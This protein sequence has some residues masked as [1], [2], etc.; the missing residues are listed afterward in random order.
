MT[1]VTS[2]LVLIPI[3]QRIRAELAERQDF[4]GNWL[5]CLR[6]LEMQPERTL[7]RRPQGRG[8]GRGG[9][10]D[11]RS[12]GSD[13]HRPKRRV[14]SDEGKSPERADPPRTFSS[15]TRQYGGIEKGLDAYI[16]HWVMEV[17]PSW[18]G[19]SD[20]PVDTMLCEW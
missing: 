6:N 18:S 15:V 19:G 1:D 4:I 14:G 3:L 20:G 5:Y 11:G 8:S 12:E 9:G 13:S 17:N 16:L 7:L 10:D 2:F